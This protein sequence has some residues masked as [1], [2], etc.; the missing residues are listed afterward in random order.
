MY[1]GKRFAFSSP[2]YRAR[3]QLAALDY[4]NNV[5]RVVKRNADGTVQ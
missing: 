1:S 2:V 5:D 4:N 3:S